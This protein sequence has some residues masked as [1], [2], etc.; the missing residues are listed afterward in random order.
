MSLGRDVARA[1]DALRRGWPVEIDGTS[2]LAIE[3]AD[4]A[5]LAEFDAGAPADILISGNRAATLKLANQRD[6]VPT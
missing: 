5:G 2:F 6:G 3:T 1:V 4:D